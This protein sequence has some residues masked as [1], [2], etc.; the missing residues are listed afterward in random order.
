MNARRFKNAVG[1]R[2]GT[3]ARGARRRQPR[4]EGELHADGRRRLLAPDGAGAGGHRAS[5]PAGPADHAGVR[6]GD[7]LV[8]V[9]GEEALSPSRLESLLAAHRAGERTTYTLLRESERRV[10]DVV[11]Q[12]LARGN[13]SAFYY[14]SLAGFFC[15]VVG[16]VVLLRRPARPGGAAL[17][18]RVRAVLPGLLDLLHGLA[19]PLRL[20]AVLDRL[21]GGAVP[22]GGVPAL[23][24]GVPRAPPAHAA[25]LA[26]PRA[27]PAGAGGDRRRRR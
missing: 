18:R 8:A 3:R 21:A 22:A 13:V 5:L 11:V 7:V 1:G 25:R 9:D 24:P 14:L 6:E 19:H 12:P 27:L 23:L 4:P 2:R 26:G 20:A 16:T 17:L 10:L 15:L